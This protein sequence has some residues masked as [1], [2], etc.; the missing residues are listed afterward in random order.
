[1]MK[2]WLKHTRR[3]LSLLSLVS[4]LQRTLLSDS[5]LE[6]SSVA[7]ASRMKH[8]NTWLLWESSHDQTGGEY[9]DRSEPQYDQTLRQNKVT[10]PLL[11]CLFMQTNNL[12]QNGNQQLQYNTWTGGL[13]TMFHTMI[14]F[15]IAISL[16]FWNE[17]LLL[18]HRD[19]NV[20]LISSS[21]FSLQ[22]H[23]WETELL[24]I[25]L[26]CYWYSFHRE[27]KP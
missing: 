16:L 23:Q 15:N 3:S 12:Q 2:L 8:W 7:S 21:I 24:L 19:T 11:L 22:S 9:E 6:S 14:I 25:Q 20:R 27:I 26:S 1:M 10:M 5:V 18:G 17:K 13:W 4:D